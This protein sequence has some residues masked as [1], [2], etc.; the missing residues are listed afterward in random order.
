MIFWPSITIQISPGL[1]TFTKGSRSCSMRPCLRPQ[2]GEAATKR[3]SAQKNLT[4]D[5]TDFTD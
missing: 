5:F 3:Q 2:R 1:V 4:T